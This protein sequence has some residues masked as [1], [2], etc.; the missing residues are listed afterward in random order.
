M[1]IELLTLKDWDQFYRLLQETVEADFPV[2]PKEVIEKR[3]EEPR[4]LMAFQKK[5]R[6]FWVAKI[7]TI[8]V[9]YLI[10]IKQTDGVSY[11]NW[12]GVSDKFRNKGIG[13]ALIGSWQDWARGEGCHKLRAST[14]NK[15]NVA[16]YE[17]SGFQ[18]EGAFVNDSYGAER[19]VLGKGLGKYRRSV[20]SG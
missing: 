1:K 10:A 14:T 6:Q 13:T 4:L 11:I 3:I 7:G 8:I 16:F 15:N 19:F 9:G 18:L 2:Y 20:K 12:L 5:S 17:K